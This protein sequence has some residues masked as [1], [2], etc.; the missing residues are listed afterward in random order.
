MFAKR[1]TDES[2]LRGLKLSAG[3]LVAL[4]TLWGLC[5]LLSAS[6]L[7]ITVFRAFK[8]RADNVSDARFL[9]TSALV[10]LIT[11]VLAWLCI[12]AAKA[13]NEARQ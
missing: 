8:E 10:I 3:L 12:R 2:D 5:A 9:L 7:V 11:S 1:G 13:L 4:G 6:M